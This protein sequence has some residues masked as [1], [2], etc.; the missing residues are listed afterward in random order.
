MVVDYIDHHRDRVVEGRPLGVEPICAVLREAGVQ[1]APSTYYAT[2]NRVPS[3][4]AVRDAQ[5]T[6]EITTVH[7]DN[8]GVYGARKVHAELVRQGTR[9]AWCTVERLMR[10][11]GLRGIRREKTRR[12]TLTEGADTPPPLDK[13][14]RQFVAAAPNQLWV[15]DLT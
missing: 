5:L 3:A 9:V 15:A 10:A 4:R 6:E 2:K 12:T 13:V 14:D 1:V 7:Q 11:E 8:L